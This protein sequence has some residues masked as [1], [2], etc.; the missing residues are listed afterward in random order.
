MTKKTYQPKTFFYLEYIIQ[1]DIFSKA[2]TYT[3]NFIFFVT[4]Q[5][6]HSDFYELL[7]NMQVCK[8]KYGITTNTLSGISFVLFLIMRYERG[9]QY[10]NS[11]LQCFQTY[12][13][14]SF[15]ALLY[16]SRIGNQLMDQLIYH[17]DVSSLNKKSQFP[18]PIKQR[19]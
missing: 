15:L 18:F 10:I 19:Y 12:K 8:Q 5:I 3:S 14:S 13:N 4:C 7:L 2:Y 16:L 17:V 11:G 9:Y 1:G 6:Q